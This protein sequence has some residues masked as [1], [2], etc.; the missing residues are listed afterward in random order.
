MLSRDLVRL[1]SGL[2]EQGHFFDSPVFGVAETAA[3]MIAPLKDNEKFSLLAELTQTG[4]S[5]IGLVNLLDWFRPR[6]D[7]QTRLPADKW[8][9]LR[10]ILAARIA[11]AD[12]EHP[13]HLTQ[14][15]GAAKRLYDTVLGAEKIQ[16]V[17]NRLGARLRNA[18]TD[19]LPLLMHVVGKS[20]TGQGSHPSDLNRDAYEFLCEI[21]RPDA[22][23]DA[24]RAAVSI[25]YEANTYPRFGVDEAAHLSNVTGTM[26]AAQFLWLYKHQS[27]I[28]EA[29]RENKSSALNRACEQRGEG[30]ADAPT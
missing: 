9:E 10:D 16:A 5:L 18:P 25:S 30:Q 26:Q 12:K 28:S 20:T 21:V 7:D 29:N 27:R 11:E 23:A 1:M 4:G 8:N 15:I 24:I 22:I 6:E 13:L 2:P 17:S 14:P 3:R 19:V